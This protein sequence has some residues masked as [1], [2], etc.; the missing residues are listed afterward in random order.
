MY[1]EFL[2][3]FA[4]LSIR[5][6]LNA[7][8]TLETFRGYWRYSAK[9][10]YVVLLISAILESLY[11][12]GYSKQL[13]PKILYAYGI[14]HVLLL[15][16]FVTTSA[17]IKLLYALF[18][19]HIIILGQTLSLLLATQLSAHYPNSLVQLVVNTC[20]TLL[21]LYPVLLVARRYANRLINAK[22]SYIITIANIIMLTNIV[23]V[24][25]MHD[26]IRPHSWA[27]FW[28]RLFSIV[29]ALMFF[30]F[31]AALLVEIDTN[32]QINQ[33]VNTLERIHHLEKHYFDFVIKTW[34]DSRRVR[35]DMRHMSVLML[36]Y[37][38]NKQL[39]KLAACLQQLNNAVENTTH[40]KLC[41]NETIDGIV[42]YWQLQS[43]EAHIRFDSNIAIDVV[44]IND[45]DL[46]IILGNTLE[47]AFYAASN[48]ATTDRF[49]EIK[50]A[51][52]ANMLLVS[53]SNGYSER[54][55]RNNDVFY[56]AKRDF[57]EIGI[58][59]ESVKQLV[60]KYKGYVKFN[61][62]ANVFTVNIAV[63]NIKE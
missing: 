4:T 20:W 57:T 3:I 24:I 15:W 28:V 22:Y 26:F 49:I 55:V 47:N 60:E 52:Q 16:H 42:G 37:L 35:H 31:L 2:T 53:I 43:T 8:I 12:A 14:I 34:Q 50:L 9:T 59:L 48:P 46:S 56:S 61:I 21:F 62:T 32:E 39:D 36:N 58:G 19:L 63:V 45:V 40:I 38:E 7:Y 44:N 10:M 29:P 5:G 6:F 27:L 11:V 41:G 30:Y 1:I 54:L 17:R 18:L 23:A 25:A 51:T 13:T 33:K